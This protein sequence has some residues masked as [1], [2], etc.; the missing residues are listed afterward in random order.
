L[1]KTRPFFLDVN[2]KKMSRDTD[3]TNYA[4]HVKTQTFTWV[5]II[6]SVIALT[7]GVIGL[8]IVLKD[9]KATQN[10]HQLVTDHIKTCQ[11]KIS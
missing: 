7:V 2:K 8:W 5:N 6:F 9:R 4:Q 3:Q 1:A 11:L 10:L